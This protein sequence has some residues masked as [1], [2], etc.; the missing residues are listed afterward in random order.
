LKGGCLLSTKSNS[1]SYALI[2]KDALISLHDLQQSL[3]P[4]VAD[5]LQEYADVFPSE[6][7][8][9]D[10]DINIGDTST[11]T[12]NQISGLIT[13]ARVHQLNNQVSS[14][15]SSYSSY[16]DSGN[17]CS[18]LLLRNDG[19]EGNRVGFARATF[20]GEQQHLVTAAPTPYGLGFWH[21]NTFWKAI[22]VYFH[23][24]QTS[25]P[26]HVG[27]GRNLHFSA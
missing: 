9:G 17:V 19:Q 20:G 2:C 22:G 13:R 3:P 18:V 10:V 15:L 23:M 11:P 7:P 1:V 14:F 16:L 12:H 26:Y 6:V 21:A 25:S 24:H 27:A 4:I 8:A 5:I